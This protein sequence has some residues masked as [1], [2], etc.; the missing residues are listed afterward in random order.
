[1]KPS[2]LTALLTFLLLTAFAQ[3]N[4]NTSKIIFQDAKAHLENMLT[5]KETSSYE[6]AIFLIENAWYENDIDKNNFDLAIQNHINNIQQL[7]EANYNFNS[8]KPKPSLLYSKE[9]L[10][11]LYKKALTN[12]AIYTYMTSSTGSI[13]SK[14]I[15]YH[16][17][18]IYSYSDP[19]ASNKW[20]NTQVI[21]LNNT[22]QGNCFALAS[23]FKIL[24]DRLHSEA[25]LCTAPSHIY[26]SHKDNLGTTYNIE[27]GSKNFPGSGMI[28]AVTYTTSE[29]IK[30]NIS[31]HELT[32]QQSI[33][34][35]LVYLAKGYE[36]KFNNNSDSFILQC[37]KTA[38]KYDDHNLNA[39][40][41]KAEYLENKLVAEQ[42][43][44]PQLQ[45]QKDFQEYQNLIANLYNLGYR[46]MPLEMKN[47]LIKS[48][49]KEKIEAP[50]A[51]VQIEQRYATISWGL[52]DE[53]HDFKPTERIRNTIFN[54][55]TQRIISFTKN[56]TLYNNYNFDPVVF[57][58]N[59]DPMTAKYPNISPYA[60]FD[61]NPI[62]NADLLGDDWKDKIA[63]VVIA[64]ATNIIPLSGSLRNSYTPNDDKDYNGA[65]KAT[66]A[67]FMGASVSMVAGGGAAVAAGT[68]ITVTGGGMALAGAPVA[69]V[70][71]VPGV[72][73]AVAGSATAAAGAT[74]AATGTLLAMNTS[75][76]MSAGYNRGGKKA[77]DSG[78]N[79]KHGDSGRSMSKADKQIEGYKKE[80]ETATGST[81]QKIMKK[82]QNVTEAAKRA[83]KGT[84]DT[85]TGKRN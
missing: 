27:L 78:K 60:C 10:E 39:L 17:P 66:D 2:V 46:E 41:L 21:H 31:Q 48:Y 75:N 72:T 68:S 3:I 38:I 49:K 85:R 84:E 71:A 29:A 25:S 35:C 70:G 79:S 80:L 53:S 76:N 13:D 65:L 1:M 69:G 24:S 83:Q 14:S 22:M 30:N 55:K 19:M 56:Q 11:Q 20:A 45:K 62:R 9:Q 81:R 40:L 44:I 6:Q 51:T 74:V 12:W 15:T 7:I 42:K 54:A 34:L 26:I 18:Y 63:G 33:A 82:I 23:L 52:F 16:K 8:T 64:A 32:T 59:V 28:S 50:Q 58:W 37:A 43:N 36:H 5:G 77:T 61:N 57:A 73:V 47:T 4:S 67:T